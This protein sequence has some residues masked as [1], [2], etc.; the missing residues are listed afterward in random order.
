MSSRRSASI[1]VLLPLLYSSRTVG[2]SSANPSQNSN[3]DRAE[4]PLG[5][6]LNH[7]LTWI[8]SRNRRFAAFSIWRSFFLRPMTLSEA[9]WIALQVRASRL[10][11]FVGPMSYAVPQIKLHTNGS[12]SRF[13][14][15]LR[16][17][18]S[19]SLFASSVRSSFA[20]GSSDVTPVL[21]FS[22]LIEPDVASSDSRS[23]NR[24][25]RSMS[26]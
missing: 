1:N 5:F 25:D 4:I 22:V 3:P 18:D 9:L 16:C 12:F 23:P 10:F 14:M 19:A 21:D 2:A 24:S 11:S 8:Q 6:H 20:W 26:A 7:W 17:L 13:L 15:L